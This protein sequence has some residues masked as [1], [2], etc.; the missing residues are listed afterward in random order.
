M[1]ESNAAGFHW[2]EE[3]P[4][5][6]RREDLL[7]EAETDT[8]TSVGAGVNVAAGSTTDAPP[9]RVAA[10]GTT[11]DPAGDG[12]QDDE[13]ALNDPDRVQMGGRSG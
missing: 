7:P 5:A 2:P 10:T 1:T 9:D 12:R 13:P 3:D 4:T 8:D 11:P 6:E